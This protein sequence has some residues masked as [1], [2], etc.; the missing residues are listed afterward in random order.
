[1]RELLLKAITLVLGCVLILFATWFLDHVAFP[2]VQLFHGDG[3]E[4]G[5]REVAH[6]IG[7]AGCVLGLW[8]GINSFASKTM[9]YLYAALGGLG[10]CVLLLYF[11]GGDGA[12]VFFGYPRMLIALLPIYVAGF[13]VLCMVRQLTPRLL[14]PKPA[15][16]IA[17]LVTLAMSGVWELAIQRFSDVYGEKPRDYVQQAQL[18]CDMTGILLGWALMHYLVRHLERFSDAASS[19]AY[20][21]SLPPDTAASR[22]LLLWRPGAKGHSAK[23]RLGREHGA[24]GSPIAGHCG[25]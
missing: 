16:F 25:Q 13:V 5:P 14:E 8:F 12:Q 9:L 7:F 3:G 19:P 2:S 20:H 18:A 10:V 23:H 22:A 15:L 17:V 11:F 24:L 1:M 4:I 6:L 21:D